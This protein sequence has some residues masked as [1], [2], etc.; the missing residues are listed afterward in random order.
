VGSGNCI[1]IVRL[2]ARLTERYL[3]AARSHRMLHKVAFVLL[4]VQKPFAPAQIVTGM[5][6]LL[7]TGDAAAAVGDLP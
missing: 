5:S 1:R 2:V 3:L 6:R 4:L 7:N